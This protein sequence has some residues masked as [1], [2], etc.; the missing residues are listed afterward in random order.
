MVNYLYCNERENVSLIDR[1]NQH[2]FGIIRI[3]FDRVVFVE[4]NVEFLGLA[5]LAHFVILIRIGP[6]F[7]AVFQSFP[8][9]LAEVGED[10]SL[11]RY[12]VGDVFHR[13]RGKIPAVIDASRQQETKD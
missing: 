7:V 5:E 8:I 1:P 9:G 12:I 11:G 13:R 4:D 6:C 3:A 10:F 2:S